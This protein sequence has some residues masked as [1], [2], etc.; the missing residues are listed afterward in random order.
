MTRKVFYTGHS[1]PNTVKSYEHQ[2]SKS[3]F[4]NLLEGPKVGQSL[5]KFESKGD[6]LACKTREPKN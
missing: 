2:H 1:C 3:Y 5:Q 4:K 6:N